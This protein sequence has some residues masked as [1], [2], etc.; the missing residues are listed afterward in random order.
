MKRL[1]VVL[2]LVLTAQTALAQNSRPVNWETSTVPVPMVTFKDWSNATT[3][4]PSIRFAETHLIR[5]TC[6]KDGAKVDSD[7]PYGPCSGTIHMQVEKGAVDCEGCLPDTSLLRIADN[8][9]VF[10]GSGLTAVPDPQTGGYILSWD[11]PTGSVIPVQGYNLYR[12]DELCSL[13][14]KPFNKI[15]AALIA[16]LTFTDSTAPT[17]IKV[18]YVVRSFDGDI[19]SVDSNR[20]SLPRPPAPVNLRNP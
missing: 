11:A 13:S 15:N 19:E 6:L 1:L 14:A 4:A 7:W 8:G 12:K 20:L 9:A 5:F 3:Y 16:G 17:T 18:C 2:L 10:A